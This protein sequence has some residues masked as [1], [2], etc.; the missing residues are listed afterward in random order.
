MTLVNIKAFPEITGVNTD[1]I[2][3]PCRYC[4]TREPGITNTPYRDGTTHVTLESLDFIARLAALA[5]K[6]R[7]NLTPYYSL[8]LPPCFDP[9]CYE[10]IA[11]IE[12]PYELAV[13]MNYANDMLLSY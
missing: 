11:V 4:K 9:C 12:C 7:V 8:F 2:Q 3:L 13:R 5:P 1:E 6:P 10:L